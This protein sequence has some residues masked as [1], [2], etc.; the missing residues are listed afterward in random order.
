MIN[1]SKKELQELSVNKK[2]RVALCKKSFHAFILF[3]QQHKFELELADFHK[4]II[5]TFDSEQMFI[6]ILG[7]RGSGKSALVKSFALWKLIS[8]NSPLTILIRDTQE[9]AE[10]ELANIRKEIE[11]NERL[12]FDFGINIGKAKEYGVFESFNQ[13][14]ITVNGST[15]IAKATYSRVRGINFSRT[16]M[17]D[18]GANSIEERISTV[19]VDDGQD[20]NS[21]KTKEG[22]SKYDQWINTEVLPATKKGVL[23][24]DVKIVIIGNLVHKDCHIATME[25]QEDVKV[26]RFAIVDENGQP[27]WKALYPTT[28]YVE[29]EKKRTLMQGDGMGNIIWHREFMLELIDED[30]QIIKGSDIQYYSKEMLQKQIIESGVGVDF[31][32]SDK[33]KAD[34]TTM[35]KAVLIKNDNGEQRLL[36]LPDPFCEKVDV[37]NTILKAKY[38]NSYMAQPCRWYAESNAYQKAGV[39]LMERAG[40]LVTGAHTS[41]DKRTNLICISMHIKNGTVMFPEKGC[42]DLITQLVGFGIEKHDDLVDGLIRVV[43]GMLNKSARGD[44]WV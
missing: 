17:T 43:D 9:N 37:V 19:I 3:Y 31:A 14:Q 35:V 20:V 25:R 28:E 15:I 4:E 36:I 13:K 1:L 18:A 11:T 38:I 22:R 30:D 29:R 21:A 12:R 6:A 16:E 7:F 8:G 40:L 27:T 42:E 2:L 41:K 24:D 44:F 33:E 10:F 26:H 39:Q 32:I 5:K 34:S 23:S